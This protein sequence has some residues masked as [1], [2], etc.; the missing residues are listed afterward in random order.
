MSKPLT[1]AEMSALEA[2]ENGLTDDQMDQLEKKTLLKRIK[3]LGMGAVENVLV[4]IGRAAD[5]VTG[6]PTRAAV[7]AAQKGQNPISA[8]TRQFAEDPDSAPTGKEIVQK[9]GVGDSALSDAFPGIYN[10][11]GEGWRLQKGGILDPTA[12]GAVGLGADFAVDWT[13]FIP[14]VALAK[15]G[16]KV[17]TK[18]ADVGATLAAKAVDVATG[19]RGTSH[20]LGITKSAGN[21]VMDSVSSVT[22]PRQAADWAQRAAIAKKNGIDPALLSEAIEF[23]PGSTISRTTRN[24]AEGPAGAKELERHAKGLGQINE[25]AGRQV[26]KIG[27]GK[28]PAD[29]AEAGQLIREAHNTAVGKF[30][31][32]IDLTYDSVQKY[33]PGGLVDRGAMATLE[34]KLSGIEKYAKGLVK[35]GTDAE[36]AQGRHLLRT[37]EALK[38]SN[39]S[40]KQLNEQ[41]QWIGKYAFSDKTPLGAIPPDVSKMRDLYGTINDALEKTVRKHVNPAFADEI[42]A[43]NKK[44]TGFINDNSHL[45]KDV[46]GGNVPDERVFTRLFSNTLQVG[47]LKKILS[48]EDFQALKGAYMRTLLKTDGAGNILFDSTL[49]NF[50]AN[51]PV[52]KSVFTSQELVDVAEVLRLGRDYGSPILSS[53]GTGASS[54]F[55]DIKRGV[56]EGLI[57]RGIVEKLKKKARTAPGVPKSSSTPKSLKPNPG[58]QTGAIDG[59]Y[60]ARMAGYRTDPMSRRLKAL[61]GMSVAFPD[62]IIDSDKAAAERKRARLKALED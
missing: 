17:G 61:Q 58:G 43:N 49:K 23:G 24:V 6:A 44:M 59:E 42:L 51:S 30:F 13:N 32:D 38:N 14:P 28:I 48:P 39:G 46:L 20:A 33:F 31:K 52:M 8:F 11:S 22:K 3:E 35:R 19:T 57:N 45:V 34:S 7:S 60:L 50:K 9:A 10:Q 56:S 37:T 40:F 41:R 5:S 55:K 21:A 4:P 18:T 53:S 15:F 54:L 16:V 26:E 27:G 36:R 25:A 62:M 1:D 47:N 2:N 12:S 29:T